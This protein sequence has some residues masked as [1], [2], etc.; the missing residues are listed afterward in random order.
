MEASL[1]VAFPDGEPVSTSPGNAPIAGMLRADYTVRVIHARQQFS[2]GDEI[3][4][5]FTGRT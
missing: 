1:V 4:A 2:H 3:G 5:R